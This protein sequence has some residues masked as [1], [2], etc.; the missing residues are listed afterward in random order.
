M[1]VVV[2]NVIPHEQVPSSHGHDGE[3]ATR[4]DTARLVLD[5]MFDKT[6]LLVLS[7][8]HTE[9]RS[10]GRLSLSLLC[11]GCCSAAAAVLL[12]LLPTP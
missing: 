1:L 8:T 9:D 2:A 11:C 12:R 7:G 10:R 6:I 3:H 4:A 5:A